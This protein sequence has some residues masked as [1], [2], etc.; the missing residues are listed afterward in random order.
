MKLEQY[1]MAY[2]VEQDRLRAILPDGV[3]SLRP[4]LRINAEIRNNK[5]SYL[6]FNTAIEK[7]GF[8][9]WLNI[10]FWEDLPFERVGK[11]VVFK[12]ELLEISFERVGIEGACP[13]E[14]DNMGCFFGDVLR[15]PEKITEPK[16]FCDCSFRWSIETGAFGKSIGKTLPAIPTEIQTVYPKE[17]F[18]V[19]AAA[20]IPCKQVLG[21]YV[22]EFQR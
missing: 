7:D 19:E 18:T 9:G 11:R 4:V 16:E 5:E 17:A 10:G 13:A 21:A 22:V 8:K 2:G 20:K 12:T 3:S 1:V 15:K 6:E 14:K